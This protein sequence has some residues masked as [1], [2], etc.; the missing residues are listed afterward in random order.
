MNLPIHTDL[1]GKVAVVTG[2]GGVLCSMFARALAASG[3]KV[4][5][6]S[7]HQE[8]VQKVADMITAE[9]GIAAAYA[10]NVLDRGALEACHEKVMA[11]L[12]SCDI[13]I[14]GA[15]GNQPGATTE[16]EYFE[17]GDLDSDT[18]NFFQSRAVGC[19]S[20]VSVEFYRIAAADAGFCAGYDRAERVQYYQHFIDECV[21]PADENPGLLGRKGCR[22]QF[23]PV[24]GGS[25]Q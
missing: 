4:A 11:D 3:A 23:H 19:G 20:G 25:L 18:K 21:Y 7:L 10:C 13:L 6:I 17:A 16:K 8:K 15:G 22:I 14:N 12:G 24:A 9:G 2:A 5:A 1:S